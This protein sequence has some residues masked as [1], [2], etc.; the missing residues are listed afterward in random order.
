MVEYLWVFDHVGFFFVP[1]IRDSRNRG[2]DRQVSCVAP[3]SGV[4]TCGGRADEL[5]KQEE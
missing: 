1:G 2:E 4:T 5:A 3:L